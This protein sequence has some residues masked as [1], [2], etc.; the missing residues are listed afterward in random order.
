LLY[1]KDV[2]TD[3]VVDYPTSYSWFAS[4]PLMELGIW[5]PRRTHWKQ[6]HYHY[7]W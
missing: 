3:L 7:W 2:T 6:L 1:E 5:R 4:K